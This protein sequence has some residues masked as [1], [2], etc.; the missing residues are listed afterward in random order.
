MC[1]LFFPVS[2]EFETHKRIDSWRSS[3]FNLFY[4]PWQYQD[5]QRFESQILVVRN[6][7]RCCRTYCTMRHLPKC[8]SRRP[9][10]HRIITN[11]EDPIM[12]MRGNRNELY[13]GITPYLGWISFYM[14]HSGSF[15][16]GC[17]LHSNQVDLFGSQDCR[18]IHDVPKED[19]VR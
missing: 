15:D 3:W 6:E 2:R 13:C 10:T 19:C 4:S 7:V 8:K 14:V 16:K 12:K 5:V 9:E 11:F 17:P 1:E 18:V